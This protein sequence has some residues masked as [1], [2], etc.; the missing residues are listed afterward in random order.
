MAVADNRSPAV[1]D[2]IADNPLDTT[3]NSTHS[4]SGV[5]QRET[6]A[7]FSP[8]VPQDTIVGGCFA[9][10][11]HSSRGPTKGPFDYHVCVPIWPI[12]S[13]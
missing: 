13:V 2:K 9:L 8:L 10:G 12:G 3:V 11:C 1:M 7:S 6:T 5:W 4:I